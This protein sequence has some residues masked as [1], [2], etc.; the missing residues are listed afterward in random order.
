MV[1]AKKLW[2]DWFTTNTITRLN[3]IPEN[4]TTPQDVPREM[5]LTCAPDSVLQVE[6]EEEDRQARK[7]KERA[8]T[9]EREGKQT[10]K[11]RENK[12]NENEHIISADTKLANVSKQRESKF[13]QTGASEI[14]DKIN[15]AYLPANYEADK[16][17]QTVIQW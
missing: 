13:M 5:K 11:L 15:Q 14:I 7:A 10:I 9:K 2:N 8:K 1:K 16:V 12:A 4:E 3:V 6:N 17:L